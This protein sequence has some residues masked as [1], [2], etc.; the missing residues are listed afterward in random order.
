M[1]A[2][3]RKKASAFRKVKVRAK[4]NRNSGVIDFAEIVAYFNSR[5]N[6]DELVACTE[7]A[8]ETE[9]VVASL[10]D[11][12]EDFEELFNTESFE[13]FKAVVVELQPEKVCLLLE[14]FKEYG[15]EVL[16]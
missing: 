3:S 4:S 16:K 15:G 12:S 2:G 5:E 10:V 9:A 13:L 14:I 7:E 6:F 11:I 8:G 1:Q